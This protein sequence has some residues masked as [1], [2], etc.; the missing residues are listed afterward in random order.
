[1]G[2][3]VQAPADPL[4]AIFAEPAAGEG[5]SGAPPLD[6]GMFATLLAGILE[7][8][9]P[10]PAEEAAPGPPPPVAAE[11]EGDQTPDDPALALL[12][13]LA[14]PQ[15]VPQPAPA[16]PAT[17][18]AASQ[19]A[20]AGTIE[21]AS[22]AGADLEPALPAANRA[23]TA[24]VPPSEGDAGPATVAPPPPGDQPPLQASGS[25][26]PV[27]AP[28]AEALIEPPGI[29]VQPPEPPAESAR[30][31]PAEAA[32]PPAGDTAPATEG[33]VRSVGNA[34]ESAPGQRDSQPGQKPENSRPLPRASASGIA[35]AAPNS[36]VGELRQAGAPEAPAPEVVDAPPAAEPPAE[37]PQQ[38]DQ[39]A[40]AVI[41][42]VEA[43][44][45]EARIHLEP[46]ELGEVTIHVRTDGDEVRIEI[47]AE[48]PDAA[49]LL[50]DHTQDLSSLLGSRGLNLSDVNVGVGGGNAGSFFE[51]RQD[52]PRPVAGEFAAVLGLDDP[53]SASR[54]N[55]LRAAYNPDGALLYRV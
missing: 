1:M 10:A 24:P 8:Q 5:A 11:D 43:G 2:L 53:S 35:H 15:A 48:R 19:D 31:A 52:Q 18:P 14:M 44:G 55:R 36:A 32:E 7:G 9:L 16:M 37:L 45:G 23:P 25:A 30:P 13:S 40:S 17:P 21:A 26:A 29:V 33:V 27:E 42:R 54:H 39:V 46:L 49:R 38:V 41:E 51:S 50:R 47:R 34:S 28:A 20:P 3:A 22:V 4:L 12:A 6:E